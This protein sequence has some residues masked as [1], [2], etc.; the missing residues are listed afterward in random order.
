[1]KRERER[2]RERERGERDDTRRRIFFFLVQHFVIPIVLL[3]R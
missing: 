2:E 1:M 3:L